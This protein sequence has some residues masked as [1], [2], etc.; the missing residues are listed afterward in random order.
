MN[1]E[2]KADRSAVLSLQPD[3]M[4]MVISGEKKEQNGEDSCF[5]ALEK[6]AALIGVYDGSGGSGARTYPE[7][8]GKTGAY[9]ASRA[10]AEGTFAWFRRWMKAGPDAPLSTDDLMQEISNV[11][12]IWHEAT[13][14]QSMLKS[15][16]TREFPT[17]FA[18]EVVLP[19]EEEQKLKVCFLWSGDSRCYVMDKS[20]LHQVSVDDLAVTDALQNLT[21]DAPMRNVISASHPYKINERRLKIRKPCVLFTATDGCFGY[22]KSPMEFERLLIETLAGAKCAD[23]WRTALGEAFRGTA[24]DDFTLCALPFGFGSFENLQAFF[25]ERLQ[26]LKEKYFIPESGDPEVIRSRWELY[27]KEYERYQ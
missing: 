12:G 13:E 27:R 1:T 9:I 10:A 2:N 20:G 15:S 14:S 24:G 7:F 8:G 4:P 11:L 21:E 16:L 18:G 22:L 17:T 5:C 3:F 23:G 19:D 25:A 26:A 6:Q